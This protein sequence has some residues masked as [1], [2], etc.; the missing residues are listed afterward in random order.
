M[1]P[2]TLFL[3]RYRKVLI[4]NFAECVGRLKAGLHLGVCWVFPVCDQ[5]QQPLGFAA[6]LLRRPGG[7]VRTN[8]EEALSPKYSVLENVGC[9]IALASYTK[10]SHC[11]PMTS[12]PEDVTRS[13]CLHGSDRDTCRSQSE[14]LFVGLATT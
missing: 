6:R 9:L 10:A 4:G 13:E 7:P 2:G 14:L 5:S 1:G 11:F 8:C 3:F 12:I